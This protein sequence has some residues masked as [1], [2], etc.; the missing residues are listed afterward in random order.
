MPLLDTS[1]LEAE[2]AATAKRQSTLEAL[3]AKRQDALAA[4]LRAEIARLKSGAL[5]V[6]ATIATLTKRQE[7]LAKTTQGREHMSAENILRQLRSALD[8]GQT[9]DAPGRFLYGEDTYAQLP[10]Q[11]ITTENPNLF[12]SG[13]G[14]TVLECDAENVTDRFITVEDYGDGTLADARSPS[15]CN[16]T[17]D[18]METTMP[19]SPAGSVAEVGNG[20]SFGGTKVSD[21]IELDGGWASTNNVYVKRFRGIGVSARVGGSSHSRVWS[22]RNYT[23]IKLTT[24][25]QAV[26]DSFC[27]DNRDSGLEIAASAGNCQA[28]QVH[29]YGNRIACCN[30]GGQ[31]FRAQ[32]C[33]FA[34]S[35][36]GYLGHST[37]SGSTYSTLTNVLFN[38]NWC[39]CAI[40]RGSYTTLT[41]CTVLVQPKV[42]ESLFTAAGTG[43]QHNNVTG[44]PDHT[45]CV[46]LDIRAPHFTMRGGVIRLTPTSEGYQGTNPTTGTEAV[47]IRDFE[48]GIYHGDYC[49]IKCPLIDN[50]GI[51]GSIGI[52]VTGTRKGLRVDCEIGLQTA[53]N[54]N[55]K[56]TNSR[57]L[58]AD[59]ATMTDCQ[60]IFRG[61]QSDLLTDPGKYVD[62]AND[63][64]SSDGINVNLNNSVTLIRSDTG[65]TLALNGLDAY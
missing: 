6:R 25:D 60:F 41:G 42:D 3:L 55:W 29:C 64:G 62:L 51:A 26:A 45:G 37:G 14:R 52:R 5:E 34:D 46:G 56:D 61:E 58:V 30:H 24:S 40:V 1:K 23:G 8:N 33:T 65:A 47:W 54:N 38:K 35:T 18:G 59:T 28:S 50:D 27:F 16:M 7:T 63:W 13:I 43:S 19:A 17:I 22:E 39:R 12:G 32:N 20:T 57:V 44:L 2:F 48:S 11:V 4:E 10:Q 21:G 15:V 53:D 9:I 49:T 36:I 31:A